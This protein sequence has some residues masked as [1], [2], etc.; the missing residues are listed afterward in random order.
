MKG[1]SIYESIGEPVGR[2]WG[3]GRGR[4][5]GFS[6]YVPPLPFVLFPEDVKLEEPKLN[7]FDESMKMLLRKGHMYDAYMKV[8]P[9]IVEDADLKKAFF[10]LL[11]GRKRMH[12]ERFSDRKK[13]MFS[14]D[15][16]SQILN[17]NAFPKELVQGTSK[18]MPSRKKFRWNPE[19]E[20]KKLAFFEELE[21]KFEGRQDKADK[22]KKDGESEDE[23]ENAED[24]EP[25][26]DLSDDDYNQNEYFDDDEDDYN[27][28]E[29]GNDEDVF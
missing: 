8:S 13:S 16:L 6:T 22:E 29:E 27:D 10:V 25:E 11:S 5:G 2:G 23:D 4:G 3:G 14:R 15:S 9:Y 7:E 1:H 28:V 19:A 17:F 18:G 21:K 24:K 20:A 26:E 12:I